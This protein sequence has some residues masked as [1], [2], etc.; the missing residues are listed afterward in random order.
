MIFVYIGVVAVI[1]Y[2]AVAFGVYC[3]MMGRNPNTMQKSLSGF[4]AAAALVWPLFLVLWA[5]DKADK[6]HDDKR[7]EP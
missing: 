4:V 1:L 2:L 3:W 7:R 5:L 6:E